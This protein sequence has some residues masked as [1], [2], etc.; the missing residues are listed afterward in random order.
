MRAIIL[1]FY[2]EEEEKVVL[3]STSLDIGIYPYI[4][5]FNGF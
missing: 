5:I 2:Y 4:Y 3:G 1:V